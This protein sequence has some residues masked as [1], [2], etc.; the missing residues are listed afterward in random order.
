MLQPKNAIAMLSQERKDLKEGVRERMRLGKR[1]ERER[2]GC[3]RL[4][5][6]AAMW[7]ASS[8]SWVL[9]DAHISM[10]REYNGDTV[11]KE[12]LRMY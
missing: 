6:S 3:R 9:R 5:D 2:I 8:A 11:V 7:R 1:R 10:D 12:R 4:G